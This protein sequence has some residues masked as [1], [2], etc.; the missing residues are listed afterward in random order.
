MVRNLTVVITSLCNNAL[1]HCK[2]VVLLLCASV[3]AESSSV[4]LSR[5]YVLI[6]EAGRC[7]DLE[8]QNVQ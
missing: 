5:Q 4:S 8:G 7:N 1:R 6:Q 3:S 2:P